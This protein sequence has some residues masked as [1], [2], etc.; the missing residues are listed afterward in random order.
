MWGD[1][2]FSPLESSLSDVTSQSI[3]ACEQVKSIRVTSGIAFKDGGFAVVSDKV[4][5]TFLKMVRKIMFLLYFWRKIL[6][7]VS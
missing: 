7:Q 5:F 3:I 6:I 2:W 1:L 4:T